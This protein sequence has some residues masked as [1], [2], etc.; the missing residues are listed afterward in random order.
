[1]FGYISENET[2]YNNFVINDIIN[3]WNT[4]IKNK[5]FVLFNTNKIVYYGKQLGDKDTISSLF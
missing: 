4:T 1:M 2:I 3:K 5:Y